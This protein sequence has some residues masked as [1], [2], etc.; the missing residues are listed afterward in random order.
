MSSGHFLMAF[1]RSFLL[2]LLCLLLGAGCFKGNLAAQIGDLYAAGDSRSSDAFQIYYLA[3]NTAVI[4]S[5]L[6]CGTLGEVYGYHYGFAAAGIG[7]VLGLLIYLRGR[8]WLPREEP[9]LRR[10]AAHA[11]PLLS[12]SDVRKIVLM[13]ALLP[14]LGLALVGNMQIF[15]AYLLW[16]DATYRLQFFG[17]KMPVTWLLSMGSVASLSA[18]AA[19]VVFWRW[20]GKTR[21]QPSDM[22][23]MVFGSLLLAAAPLTLSLVSWIA[24]ATGQKISLA[25]AIG[26]ECFN[27]I[28]YAN[29]LPVGLALYA[30]VAPRGVAGMM[31]S[32][33]SLLIFFSNMIVGWLGGLLERM[34]AIHFWL[35]HAAIIFGAA[36]SLLLMRGLVDR[37]LEARNPESVPA[38]ADA[39]AG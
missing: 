8:R 38:L 4:G 7:M 28:G 23:K 1:D 25:W 5:P 12:P 27:E 35:L 3:I 20:W 15:N 22:S 10:T 31:V 30:R 37:V 6:V 14:I 19:S 2:A 34:S 33:Y 39:P 29:L 26:F 32:V 21:V 24:A 13:L 17:M 11:R 9:V 18:I 36:I 16:A